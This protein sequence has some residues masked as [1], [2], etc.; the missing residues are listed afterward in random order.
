MLDYLLRS[1]NIYIAEIRAT[2]KM[3]T[4]TVT[5]E[6]FEVTGVGAAVSPGLGAV[7]V[8]IGDVG[9]VTPFKP[10]M[11]KGEKASVFAS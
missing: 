4:R 1:L 6:P 10:T 2:A 5:I 3:I 11:A 7:P 9:T 8:S